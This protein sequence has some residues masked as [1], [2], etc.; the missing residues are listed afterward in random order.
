MPS[1]NT[2]FVAVYMIA[3]NHGAFI[4]KAIGSVM[5]QQ[6]TYPYKLF[7][8]EDNS[9]DDTRAICL[10]LKDKY[11]DKIELFLNDT[12]LGAGANARQIF[13]VCFSSG[14]KYVALLEGD[15]Y[16]TDERKLQKQTDFLDQ[17]PEYVLC[18]HDTKILKSNGEVVDDFLTNVPENHETLEDFARFGNYIHTPSV[19]FR[20]VI[21]EFPFEFKLAIIG[22][23]FLYMMLAEHGKLKYLRENM[24]VYRHGVGIF[25]KQSLVKTV[26]ATN[27]LFACLLSYL[28]DEN[29]RKIILER[30]IKAFDALE[31]TV[32]NSSQSGSQSFLRT[33]KY[34]FSN[35]GTPSKIT[36]KIG[37]KL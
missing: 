29:I 25:S 9:P 22:D 2:P 8:G 23:F 30:Q 14:A 1:N 26:K 19:V 37:S 28:K 17:N 32:K 20:N 16:W 33:L 36:K 12:N 24:A 27:R 11:P 34:I 15:D 3:Y 13:D 4:E 31:E 6:T 5:M 35:L 18:F 7:I 21:A 10:K